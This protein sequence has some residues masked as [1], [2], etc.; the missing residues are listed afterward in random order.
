MARDMNLNVG[1]QDLKQGTNILT[2]E[3][4]PALELKRST[5]IKWFNEALGG[6]GLTPST[7]MMLTGSP[8]V[9]KSTFFLQLAD[10]LTGEGHTVLM[11]TG[12]ES[13][14][15][16][17]MVAKRLNLRHG[18]V[19]GQDIYVGDLLAHAD[20]L[21]KKKPQK[22]VI[23]LQDSLQTLNDGYYKDGGTTSNTPIRCCEALTNWAKAAYDLPDGSQSFGIVI[24]VGQV[25]KSGEFSGKNGIK[26]M[27]DVHGSLYF[28]EDPKSET[29][30]QRLFEIYKNRFGCNGKTFIL[31]CG[32]R[33]LFEQ[34]SYQKGA[35]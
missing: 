1:I 10:A 22:Q 3:V 30:G 33:G 11:N 5:G 19:A 32:D 34:G 25:N 31:G 13:L 16:V 29:Y 8:G 21:R 17:R 12:E 7:S 6:Q 18:F 26:H 2:I 35:K 20:A 9:G 24:F 14:Y 4:P 28:D 27:V 15:Q 23:I